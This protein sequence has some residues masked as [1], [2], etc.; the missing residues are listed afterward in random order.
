MTRSEAFTLAQSRFTNKNLF[1]HVLAVEVVMRGLAEHFQQDVEAWGLAGLLHDLDYEETMKTPERHT[2]VTL[3]LLKPYNIPEDILHAIQ[4]H[5]NLAPRQSMMDKALYAADP[6]TGLIVA[7]A[8]MHP[9]KKLAPVEVEFI[10]RR[11]KEKSFAKGANRD[12]IQSCS[13]LGLT[14]EEFTGIALRSMQ[15]ISSDLGL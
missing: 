5:N 10:L 3:E 15:S 1:K 12:Q 8:L 13:E 11:F 9:D 6:V 4:C 14:L 2:V 7:A